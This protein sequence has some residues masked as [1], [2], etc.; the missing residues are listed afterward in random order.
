MLPQMSTEDFFKQLDDRLGKKIDEKIEPVRA[1]LASLEGTVAS[2]TRQIDALQKDMTMMK[3]G[4]SSGVSTDASST[5]GRRATAAFV[6]SKIILKNFAA[7]HTSKD[8]GITRPE[9]EKLMV[10]LM[11]SVP[12]SLKPKIYV[13]KMALG[14]GARTDRIFI[15]VEAG[16]AEEAAGVFEA[17]LAAYT[18]N[19]R[20]VWVQI[21]REPATQQ[22]FSAFGKIQDF[23]RTGLL[24]GSEQASIQCTWQ[25]DF[26]I[27]VNDLDA[28]SIG[29]E[30]RMN[31]SEKWCQHVL[32]RSADE[33]NKQLR[34]FR[35][36]RQ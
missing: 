9:A 34:L 28:G 14:R 16:F 25:P 35:G 18:Y 17:G 19:G 4:N 26:H 1:G 3:T 33:V 36:R 32:S 27:V 23:I 12:E 22:R 8:T 21:E 13:A 2:H 20:K 5:A 24:N 15:P 31:F 10:S 29:V 11:E 7:Y 6:P 30:G